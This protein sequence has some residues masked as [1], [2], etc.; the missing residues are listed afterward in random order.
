MCPVHTLQEHLQT[1]PVGPKRL[2]APG[3][4]TLGPAGAEMLEGGPEREEWE[5]EI[6]VKISPKERQH[7]GN[8]L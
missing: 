8:C 7:R 2:P 1:R 4:E 6:R 5:M 3:R